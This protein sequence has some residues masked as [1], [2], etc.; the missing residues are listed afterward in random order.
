[1]MKLANFPM[2]TWKVPDELGLIEGTLT[3]SLN[4]CFSAIDKEKVL[5]SVDFFYGV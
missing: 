5:P 3:N 2:K 1:M 4:F